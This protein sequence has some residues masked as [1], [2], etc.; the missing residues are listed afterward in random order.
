MLILIRQDKTCTDFGS[1]HLFKQQA[2]HTLAND[3]RNEI[4]SALVAEKVCF[5]KLRQ[6]INL[7]QLKLKYKRRSN[8]IL[9]NLIICYC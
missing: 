6:K 9:L 3:K 8:F 7:R 2:Y 1:K 4:W 5:L